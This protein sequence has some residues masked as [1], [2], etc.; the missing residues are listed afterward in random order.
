MIVRFSLVAFGFRK[1]VGLLR[2]L[3]PSRVQN[4]RIDLVFALA[5]ARQVAKAAAF[6]PVRAICIEQSLALLLLLRRKGIS[7]S[8]RLGVQPYPF[9]AHAWVECD[10]VPINESTELIRS[11]VTFDAT[12]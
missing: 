9:L 8:L 11:V 1:T 5:T 10:G 12:W 3:S 6:V 4:Q 2:L 7:A